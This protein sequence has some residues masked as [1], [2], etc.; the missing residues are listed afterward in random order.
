M[1]SVIPQPPI[2]VS[3]FMLNLRHIDNENTQTI[4]K[5]SSPRF[6]DSIFGNFGESL[7]HG[8]SLLDEGVQGQHAVE[9]RLSTDDEISFED[10]DS[11]P[12]ASEASKSSIEVVA[13]VR[14]TGGCIV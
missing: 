10:S 9:E 6:R 3:R 5:V 13:R 11:A 1:N 4:S 8:A 7:D 2:L 12:R 14:E